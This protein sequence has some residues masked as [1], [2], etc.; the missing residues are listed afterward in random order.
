MK[1]R[2]VTLSLLSFLSYT[3]A[4]EV[5]KPNAKKDTAQKSNL[6]ETKDLTTEKTDKTKN[7]KVKSHKLMWCILGFNP[8][9]D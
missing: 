1:K 9:Q 8:D 7:R 6:K 5:I 4:N 3:G 2:L